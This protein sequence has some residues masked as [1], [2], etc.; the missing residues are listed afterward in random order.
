MLNSNSLCIFSTLLYKTTHNRES[1]PSIPINSLKCLLFIMKLEKVNPG[2]NETHCQVQNR[3]FFT[4]CPNR[5]KNIDTIS[6]V[7]YPHFVTILEDFFNGIPIHYEITFSCLV[8]FFASFLNKQKYALSSS[9]SN[10][11]RYSCLLSRFSLS[12]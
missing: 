11:C 3:F 8:Y 5:L 2:E 1:S 12:P 10:L 7:R 6:Q 9:S 4:C